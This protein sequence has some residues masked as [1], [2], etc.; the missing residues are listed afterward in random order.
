MSGER[1]PQESAR[2]SEAR[3]EERLRSLEL[4]GM[5]FGLERMRRLMTA[6][7][8]PQLAFPAIQVLGTNGKSST[9]RMA[10]AI[11]SAHG[12]RTGAY[13]SP[14]LVSY[15][16]RLLI[17]GRPIDADSFA[18]GVARASR[19]A[20]RVERTLADDDRVTQFELLTA[21][22]LSELAEQHV[23]VAVVEA[24]L[25]GRFDATSV[26]DSPISVLTNVGLEHQ[27]W[28][29]PTI[30]DIAGEK[31]AVLAPGGTL[32]L[33]RRVDP[34]VLVLAERL[35][36]ER[37]ARIVHAAEGSWRLAAAGAFQQDNFALALA[38]AGVQLAA[39]GR[40][41]DERAVALAA[42]Q[43]LVPGRLEIVSEDPLTV[44]DGAH[45]ADA[46]RALLASLDEVIPPGPLALVIGVLDDKDAAAMLTTLLPRASRAY[47]TAPPST[48]ALPAATLQSL[49]AQLGFA[50]SSVEPRP[51][52]ALAAAQDWARANA[53]SVLATG[54]V[55]LVGDL[56][57]AR[58]ETQEKEA[59]K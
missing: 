50:E 39:L 23:D 32:V 1:R 51:S 4:F 36:T 22:A 3:V 34:E 14:H 16:E 41:L 42:A 25:G 56:T 48:R 9:T 7:G 24:G 40:G 31:L 20:E 21:A 45:N 47:F 12:L 15:R 30:A 35:A 8:S 49:A 29:G 55:Y 37:G 38:A 6:L 44:F 28:L 19:G 57:A 33:G 52:R 54:S 13:L 2:W 58:G 46:T 18:A 10:A 11:L 43:T 5:R 17:D 59:R 27:R 53:A 26:I